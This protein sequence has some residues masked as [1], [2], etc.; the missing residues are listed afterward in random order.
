MNSNSS[1]VYVSARRKTGGARTDNFLGSIKDIYI[2]VP[3]EDM[4]FSHLTYCSP[5]RDAI[6]NVHLIEDSTQVI[7]ELL[8]VM[9]RR[10]SKKM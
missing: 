6:L 8:L 1:I 3:R 9:V 4:T 10:R 2:A 5:I 7:F